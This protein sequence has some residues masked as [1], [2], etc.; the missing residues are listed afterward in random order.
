[1]RY[2]VNGFK[3]VP[4]RPSMMTKYLQAE[5]RAAATGTSESRSG[6]LR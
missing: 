3:M 1:M 4:V 2:L 6:R 5:G